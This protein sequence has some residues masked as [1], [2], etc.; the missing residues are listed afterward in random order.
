MVKSNDKILDIGVDSISKYTKILRACQTIFWNG[1]L[2]YVEKTPYNKGT[3]EIAKI[4]ANTDCF[5]AIG[6]GDTV[7]VIEKLGLNDQFSFLS[8]GGG[9]LMKFF[10]GSNM[11]IL[12]KLGLDNK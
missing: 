9:A 1:P 12:T 6:G 4:I 8:T 11:P 7:P 2:G 3:S 10:E 5:S